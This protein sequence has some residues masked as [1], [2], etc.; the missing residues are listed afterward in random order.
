M[1]HDGD[2]LPPQPALWPQHACT[3]TAKARSGLLSAS[4]GKRLPLI[5]QSRTRE[6][7]RN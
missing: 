7:R 5:R 4:P 1:L 6:S 2:F 3:C